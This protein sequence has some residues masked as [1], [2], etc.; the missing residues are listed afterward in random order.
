MWSLDKIAFCDQYNYS[1]KF[2]DNK[3]YGPPFEV[4]EMISK[5]GVK[6]YISSITSLSPRDYQI[7]GP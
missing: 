5:E 2:Q 4:N 3:F 1:Y 7:D 6:D